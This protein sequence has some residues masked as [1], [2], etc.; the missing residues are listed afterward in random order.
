MRSFVR[1]MCM[2]WHSLGAN[3]EDVALSSYADV[4]IILKWRKRFVLKAVKHYLMC[5]YTYTICWDFLLFQSRRKDAGT[6]ETRR[7]KDKERHNQRVARDKYDLRCEMS[8]RRLVFTI[9]FHTGNPCER[10]WSF[11]CARWCFARFIFRHLILF[12]DQSIVLAWFL[13]HFIALLGHKDFVNGNRLNARTLN[14]HPI[15][16]SNSGTERVSRVYAPA[17][18]RETFAQFPLSLAFK[19]QLFTWDGGA[20]WIWKRNIIQ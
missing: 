6:T 17:R 20:K 8:W 5:T 12:I 10:E 19:Q 16:F 18:I 4:S 2:N 7:P 15:Q 9:Y 14:T 1:W 3:K 11:G 13:F